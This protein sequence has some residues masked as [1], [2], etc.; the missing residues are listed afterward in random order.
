MTDLDTFLT[1]SVA[2]EEEAAERHDELADMMEVHN[3]PEVAATFRKL[4]HY[5]RLH[6]G[7]I[8]D[9]SKGFDLPAIAPWDFGWETMEGPETT[10][11]GEMNYLMTTGHAL[12]VAMANEQRAH[13]FY[14]EISKH[15][16]DE[17]VRAVAGEFAEEEK[18]HLELLEKW[19][20]NHPESDDEIQYD[21]DPPHMPE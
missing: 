19:L 21:P 18:E 11:I 7:E 6:A 10:D 1:Y 5:S 13:D 8:R 9:R 20:E 4:A 17:A 3:N 2:L 12:K 16:P 15:S 14:F